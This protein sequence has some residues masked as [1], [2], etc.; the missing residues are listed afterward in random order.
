MASIERIRSL[1]L[2]AV[3]APEDEIQG[4]SA[5]EL[6]VLATRLGRDLPAPLAALLTVCNGARVGPGGLFGQRPQD[7]DIDLPSYLGLFPAWLA[8]G[9]LPVAGDG[10]GNYYVLTGDGSVGFVDASAGPDAL[11]GTKYPDL[12]T[13]VESILIDDQADG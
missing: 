1:A 4:A 6:S 10:C 5:E 9:W 12:F 7:P 2:G 13:F 8:S 11:G 3:R